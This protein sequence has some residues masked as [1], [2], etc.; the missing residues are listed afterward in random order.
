MAE[1]DLRLPPFFPRVPKQCKDVA[2]VFFE[3]FSKEAEYDEGKVGQ[4]TGK[5]I[6]SAV[7][8]S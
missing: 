3:C 4:P 6:N 2:A 7:A 8:T 5:Q 1:D